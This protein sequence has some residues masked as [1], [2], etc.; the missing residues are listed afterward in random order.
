MKRH[1]VSNDHRKMQK[2]IQKNH[3]VGDPPGE[4]PHSD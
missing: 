3:R 4:I 1:Q 2:V